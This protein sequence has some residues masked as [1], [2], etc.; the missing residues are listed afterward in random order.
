[1]GGTFSELSTFRKESI[2]KPKNLPK[3]RS[4][5]I[6]IDLNFHFESYLKFA[7]ILVA[8]ANE[9]WQSG[10]TPHLRMGLLWIT[11][12]FLQSYSKILGLPNVWNSDHSVCS[13]FLN[14]PTLG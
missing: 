8:W 10:S 9:R 7:S 11:H 13:M 2:S 14:S 6:E 5:S 4:K 1:M 3:V 12:P